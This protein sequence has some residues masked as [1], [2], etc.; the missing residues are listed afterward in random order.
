MAE[1][2]EKL[3]RNERLLSALPKTDPQADMIC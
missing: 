1:R 3:I 2:K